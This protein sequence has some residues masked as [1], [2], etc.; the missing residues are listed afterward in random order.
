MNFWI[1]GS[2]L[3]V[4]A[5]VAPLA[6][7]IAPHDFEK[8]HFGHIREGPSAAFLLGTDHLGRD[9]LSRIVLG[10]RTTL[11]IAVTSVGLAILLA[12]PI[13][14]LSAYLGGRVDS[15]VMR[16]NDVFISF[17]ALVFAMLV[18]GVLGPGMG[19]AILAIGILF[20][21]GTARVVRSAVLNEVDKEYVDAARVRGEGAAY[22][23]LREILPNV[24][25][26]LIVEAAVRL[27]EAILVSAA[28]GYIGLGPPP[29]APDWGL[30]AAEGRTYM[31]QNPW[32]VFGPC[33]AIVA[34]VVGVNL[35]GDGLKQMLIA[36]GSPH[37][38]GGR[39]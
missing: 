35:F 33:L 19:N 39:A 7:E 34:S 36:K 8:M 37:L 4:L 30:M 15:L 12:V 32:P 23:V 25:P 9:V 10:T 28:L 26:T 18:I 29:P 24:Y 3:L 27:G 14:G 6:P 13:G 16:L 5:L 1:G 22:I 2:I 38:V 11:V 31:V 21:P 17:P 20:A